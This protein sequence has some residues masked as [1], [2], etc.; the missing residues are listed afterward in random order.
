MKKVSV[1]QANKKMSKIEIKD[2]DLSHQLAEDIKFLLLLA[3]RKFVHNSHLVLCN[4]FVIFI[5]YDK[6]LYGDKNQEF[7]QKIIKESQQSSLY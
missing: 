2:F 4:H 5:D 1:L 6:Y 7:V 3:E